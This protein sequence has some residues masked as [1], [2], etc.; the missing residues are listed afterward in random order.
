MSQEFLI[1]NIWLIA[2]AV[3]SGLLLVWPMLSKGAGARVSVHQATLLLNQRKAVVVDIRDDQSVQAAGQLLNSKRMPAG[4]LKGKA[5]DALAKSKDTPIIV[6]S[7][8]GVGTGKAI[9]A[10]QAAGYSE[11]FVL[12]GGMNAWKDAGM[13]FKKTS[14]TPPAVV[15]AKPP[16]TGVKKDSQE[17]M[18]EQ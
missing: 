14:Q 11:V 6:L 3:A 18:N 15:Q 13:P 10:L 5:L 16:K 12:E 8:A 7:Q 9:A 2:V 4:E 17:K 1:Q